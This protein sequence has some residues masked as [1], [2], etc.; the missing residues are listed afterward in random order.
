MYICHP[1]D[2]R[3][4]LCS[5][6]CIVDKNILVKGE[7]ECWPWQGTVVKGYGSIKQRGDGS[8]LSAHRVAYQL[9]VGVVPENHVVR[10]TC[11]NPACCNYKKHLITGTMMDN[12]SDAVIRGRMCEG[13]RH[14]AA[15]FTPELVIKFR[16]QYREGRTCRSMA[17]EFGC[18]GQAMERMVRGFTWKNIP[19]AVDKLRERNGQNNWNSVLTEHQVRIIR[20]MPLVLFSQGDLGRLLNVSPKTIWSIR[21]GKRWAHV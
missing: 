8:M 7:D 2:N 19:G 6:K 20:E 11:D 12:T 21:H 10:H 1:S 13:A 15:K 16:N 9:Y 14:H 17:R 3:S 18:C 5:L 4:T